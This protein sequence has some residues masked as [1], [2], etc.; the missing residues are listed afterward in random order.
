LLLAQD[1]PSEVKLP[2]VRELCSVLEKEYKNRKSRDAVKIVAVYEELDAAYKHKKIKSTDQ[3]KI[4]KIIRKGFDIK[5]PVDDRSFQKTGAA[6]LSGM[7]KY[8]LD[9]LEYAL[10]CKGLEPKDNDN[11]KEVSDCKQVKLFVIEAMG[12][13]KDPAA[14]KTLE[15]LL[16]KDDGE[17]IKAACKA[18][19][20]FGELE[21][22]DRKKVVE[23]LV[24][25][26]SYLSSQ[27]L[28]NPKNTVFRDRLIIVEVSFNDALQ[29]LTLRSF[30][31]APEWQKWYNDN[32]SKKKW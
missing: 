4:V 24:K 12:F 31:S 15:K 10:D 13:T 22:K 5:P 18:L 19:S 8:G 6:C 14:L 11:L 23:E 9:A 29:K 16:W 7:G 2:D 25:V 30:E 20:Y 27:V 26:Y 32:K 21:L 28:A 1:E 3:K 17:M